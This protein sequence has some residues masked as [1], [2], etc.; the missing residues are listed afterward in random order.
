MFDI[1]IKTFL[2]VV[3][4]GSFTQA[5]KHEYRSTVAIMKQVTSLEE[6]IGVKLLF[7]SH[8]G[9]TP[10]PAG[11]RLYDGVQNLKMQAD[12]LLTD[13]KQL[14]DTE[15]KIIRIGTSLLRPSDKLI[16]LWLTEEKSKNKF[17][18]Q[19]VPFIDDFKNHDKVLTDK[20]DCIVT[21]YSVKKWDKEYNYL[22]LGMSECLIG[23]S[24]S[25]PL[26]SKKYLDWSDLNKQKLFLLK[27]GKSSLV[28]KIRNEIEREHPKVQI[29]DL[30]HLYDIESFNQV[31]AAQGLVE[32]PSLW[33][34][35]HPEIK[36][37]PIN[38]Q[39]RIPYGLLYHRHPSKTMQEFIQEIKQFIVVN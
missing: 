20:M 9:V 3:K 1:R 36:L 6:E 17:E 4:L 16:N 2:L 14:A 12:G 31:I 32:M 25:N 29:C 22:P 15:R 33:A 21:P 13:V 39:Y 7:R 24:K 34:N 26:F 28:D 11:Q 18:F 10:T 27:K 30:R 38:W 5:A 37:L 8:R 35:I 23:V 19:L